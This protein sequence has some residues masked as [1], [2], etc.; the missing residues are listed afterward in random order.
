MSPHTGNNHSRATV[1]HKN[2]SSTWN[3]CEHIQYLFLTPQACVTIW[4]FWSIQWIQR[5]VSSHRRVTGS[6]HFPLAAWIYFCEQF[7]VT[8]NWFCEM[9]GKIEIRHLQTYCVFQQERWKILFFNLSCGDSH[10]IFSRIPLS[11]HHHIFTSDQRTYL[12]VGD[13]KQ[14]LHSLFKLDSHSV[15][16]FFKVN[17]WT[18]FIHLATILYNL[19][20]QLPVFTYFDLRI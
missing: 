5:C 9:W 20:L 3:F 16:T 12:L 2:H 18:I 1:T 15:Q 14:N 4:S 19:Q 13:P 6:L 8:Q 11:S 10:P 17:L 7:S